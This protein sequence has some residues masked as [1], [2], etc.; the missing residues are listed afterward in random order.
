MHAK[1]GFLD[2]SLN[3]CDEQ[4][5]TSNRVDISDNFTETKGSIV[6]LQVLSSSSAND[7]MRTVAEKQT[8]QHETI[9]API[10]VG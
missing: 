9:D 7:V 4:K 2:P 5:I 3:E 6:R 10:A 1:R 8:L